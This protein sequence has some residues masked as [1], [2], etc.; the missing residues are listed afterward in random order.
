MDRLKIALL[1]AALI[2]L[3]DQARAQLPEA[4]GRE[5]LKKVCAVCHPAEIVLGR[6]MTREQWGGIVSN[7]VGRGAKGSDE[8]LA[9]I[10]DYLAKNLP[11]KTGGT[12]APGNTPKARAGG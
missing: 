3:A 11:A 10:V 2:M 8:E 6:G 9:E 12:G 4:P 5:T 7:M 1:L